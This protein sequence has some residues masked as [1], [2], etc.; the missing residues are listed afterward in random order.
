MRCEGGFQGRT[1]K[2]VDGC[3][4]FWQGGL[5]PLLHQML[6]QT[7]DKASLPQSEWI[8]DE[9]AL[10]QYLLVCCQD[11]RGGLIDKPGKPRDF[12]HTCYTL[13]GLSVVQH[14]PGQHQKILGHNS[15]LLLATHPVYNVR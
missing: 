10:Q 7:E 9:T 11:P 5:F 2:L 4:S 14:L 12:Y 15:N 13:S 8:C 3:Y 6:S 1:N